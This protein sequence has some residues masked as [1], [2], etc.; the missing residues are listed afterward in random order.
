MYSMEY[1]KKQ[2]IHLHVICTHIINAV[3]RPSGSPSYTGI[4]YET[5]VTELL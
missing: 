3:I 1:D 5:E 4:G 2:Y